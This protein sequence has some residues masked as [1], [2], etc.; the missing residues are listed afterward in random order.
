M[1]LFISD[2]GF[3]YRTILCIGLFLYMST[4]G[5]LFDTLCLCFKCVNF[6]R[7]LLW[8]FNVSSNITKNIT[9]YAVNKIAKVIICSVY[10]N[11]TKIFHF[12]VHQKFLN[13]LKKPTTFE[14]GLTPG[15]KLP[16]IGISGQLL[17]LAFHVRRRNV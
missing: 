16:K 12:V 1:N 13:G 6:W 5:E 4:I 11:F 14:A 10:S 8:Q 7:V 17:L 2:P 9:H 3:D 15:L